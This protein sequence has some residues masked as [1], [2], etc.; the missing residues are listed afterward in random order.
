MNATW[1]D[2]LTNPA[3]VDRREDLPPPYENGPPKGAA[4]EIVTVADNEETLPQNHAKQQGKCWQCGGAFEVEGGRFGDLICRPCIKL[5]G[6]VF[7]L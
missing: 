6:E 3:P 5:N 1:T 4:I 2:H 7:G